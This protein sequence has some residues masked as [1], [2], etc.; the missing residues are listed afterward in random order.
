LI[1][2]PKTN[3]KQL[4]P[5]YGVRVGQREFPALTGNGASE[6]PSGSIARNDDGADDRLGRRAIADGAGEHASGLLRGQEDRESG[7]Q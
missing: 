5:L 4:K 7:E 6:L 3:A 2:R 1:A